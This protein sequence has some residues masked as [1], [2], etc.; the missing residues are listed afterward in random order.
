MYDPWWFYLPRAIMSG[1]IKEYRLAAIK[2]VPLSASNREWF[3][4][5]REYLAKQGIEQRAT[6]LINPE[7]I[8]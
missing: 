8:G 2:F 4:W 3:S 6:I 7:R 1:E 5:V